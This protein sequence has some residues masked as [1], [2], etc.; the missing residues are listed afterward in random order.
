M[1]KFILLLVICLLFMTGC[2]NPK[3]EFQV[4]GIIEENPNDIVGIH[5][6]V[7][8]ITNL[9]KKIE[10]YVFDTKKSF[11]KQVPKEL[12]LK[13]P[14]ELNIDYE[15]WKVGDNYHNIVLTTFVSSP[16]LAHPISEV[17]TFV[18]DS[19]QNKFLTISDVANLNFASI[20]KELLNTYKDCILIESLEARFS[21]IKDLKFTFK[22]GAIIFYFNPYEISSSS[23][24]II[25]YEFPYSDFKVPITLKEH[26]T[27]TFEYHP[28]MKKLSMEKPTIALTFDDGP[29]K[30]TKEIVE[31]LEKYEANATFFVLGN[32]V[33]NY[34]ETLQ[35][36]LEH[37]NELGNHSYNHKQLTRLSLNELKEQVEKTNS[38]VKDTL[39]YDIR[40]LR[41]TYGAVNNKL[42]KNLDMEIVLWNVD[43]LDWKL[44]NSKA[45]AKRALHDIK[46]GKI[47]LM[48]DIYK[49]TLEALKLILPELKKQGYQIVTVSELKEIQ[50]LRNEAKSR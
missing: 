18:Y 2:N 21:E 8:G 33:K 19:N 44:K 22:E 23:C 12:S 43:T 24:G 46:D 37:G 50:S 6:P 32:K 30:Y 49:S 27:K 29:S 36:V 5:Y 14:S 4:K 39:N 1:K 40:L 48:H 10:E 42:R 9:D 28:T 11:D 16:N 3:R 31:L 41:P 47:V 34:N 26:T 45:I 7:T 17:K 13:L 38:I 25:K 35:F 20:K 15:Y